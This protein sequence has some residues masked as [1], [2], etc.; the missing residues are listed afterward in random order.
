MDATETISPR[1]VFRLRST[2]AEMAVETHFSLASASLSCSTLMYEVPKK[3][4]SA[5]CVWLMTRLL[6]TD[7]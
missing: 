7:G 6:S 2:T 5:P 1:T 3:P 4:S